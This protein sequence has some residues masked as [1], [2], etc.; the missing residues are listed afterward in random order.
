[1]GENAWGAGRRWRVMRDDPAPGARNMARD[2]AL[3][4]EA[5]EGEGGVLRFYGWTPPAVSFGRN[6]PVPAG[7]PRDPADRP[8]IDVVR[9]PT[10]GRA[11]LHHQEVTYAVILPGRALGA[12]A[13]YRAVHEGLVSGLRSLGIPAEVASR[14]QVLPPDA[15]PCFGVAAPGEITLGGRKLVGSAQA[16]LDGALLQHGSLLLSPHQDRLMGLL[17]DSGPASEGRAATLAALPGGAP[18]LEQLRAALMGGLSERFGGR[19]EE[20]APTPEEKACEEGL[21]HLYRDPAWTWR[22]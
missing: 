6:E 14:G 17:G 1:M 3:A 2:H 9:R 4:R 5:R 10:G 12:R 19:W 11:V 20:A 7:F 18:P 13:L 8:G 21:L 15:G 16:R 22:R